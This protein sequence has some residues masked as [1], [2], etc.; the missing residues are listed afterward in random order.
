MCTNAN[1]L[2]PHTL[3]SIKKFICYCN[4]SAAINGGNKMNIETWEKA[5]CCFS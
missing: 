2:S 4:I 3:V 5:T 1:N